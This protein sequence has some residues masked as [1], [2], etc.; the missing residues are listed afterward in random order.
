MSGAK[1]HRHADI[2][3]ATSNRQCCWWV[4]CSTLL[5]LLSLITSSLL[6]R[7]QGCLAL[8]H[9]SVVDCALDQYTTTFQD[10][11]NSLVLMQL[12]YILHFKLTN[13]YRCYFFLKPQV[14]TMIDP[15]PF[16]RTPPQ[17]ISLTTT[18]NILLIKCAMHSQKYF[19]Y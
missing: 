7:L 13:L 1:E 19:A 8:N 2:Q 9:F 15:Y 12:S 14:L 18:T 17:N 11:R 6:H 10:S 16:F 5:C 3:K 4:L